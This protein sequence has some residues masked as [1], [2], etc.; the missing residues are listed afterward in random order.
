VELDGAE[1]RDVSERLPRYA[2]LLMMYS[3]VE[4]FVSWRELDGSWMIQELCNQL[5]K[6]PC[7]WNVLDL[8]TFVNGNVA[9]SYESNT[10]VAHNPTSHLSH[11]KRQMPQ[12]ESTLTKLLNFSR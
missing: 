4:N 7:L 9:K 2:D 6:V 10:Y 8:M 1:T 11:Q 3:T 12:L 5:D